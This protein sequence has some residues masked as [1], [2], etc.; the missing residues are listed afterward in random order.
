MKHE[1]HGTTLVTKSTTRVNTAGS[2]SAAAKQLP[3]SCRKPIAEIAD[4]LA[5]SLSPGTGA[6]C[7]LTTA[8]E[9]HESPAA[10]APPESASQCTTGKPTSC[11][12]N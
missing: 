7:L 2:E 8:P 5:T 1:S 6:T 11:R 10:H 9:A 12:M 4:G 3:I